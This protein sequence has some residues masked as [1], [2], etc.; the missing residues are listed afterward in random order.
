MTD[1]EKVCIEQKRGN[2]C[3]EASWGI[4]NVQ[5]DDEMDK[6]SDFIANQN[7][8]EKYATLLVFEEL[9]VNVAKYAYPNSQ[10]AIFVKIV[11]SDK[12]VEML[13]VDA[14]VPFDPTQY[15]PSKEKEEDKCGVG[16]HGIELVI[17]YSKTISYKRDM[18][19]NILNILV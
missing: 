4:T 7:I 3:V 15:K 5:V 13:F 14:G 17:D 19:L 18:G 11:I 12:G 9:Y 16:G 1:K 10:G 8:S 6:I 2:N